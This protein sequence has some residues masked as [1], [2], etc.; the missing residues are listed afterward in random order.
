MPA[1]ID[2]TPSHAPTTA[3]TPTGAVTKNSLPTQSGDHVLTLTSPVKTGSVSPDAQGLV[4]APDTIVEAIKSV[5]FAGTGAGFKN[6]MVVVPGGAWIQTTRNADRTWNGTADL[7]AQPTGPYTVRVYGW[8]DDVAGIE[9][10]VALDFVMLLNNR[11]KPVALPPDPPQAKGMKLLHTDD[12]TKGPLNPIWGLGVRPDG[13]QW[14]SGA[15]FVLA[16]EPEFNQVFTFPM[17]SFLRIRAIHN[18]N[19]V[20]P[21]KW[22]RKFVS[23]LLCTVKP[24]GSG[25][26]TFRK[27]YVEAR[28]L[29]PI[30]KGMWPSLWA[31]NMGMDNAGAGTHVSGGVE[32]DMEFYCENPNPNKYYVS[33]GVINWAGTDGKNGAAG[34]MGTG[35]GGSVINGMWLD[36]TT[37]VRT[38]GILIDDT[39]VT[40]FIDDKQISQFALPRAATVDKFYWMLDNALSG[41]DWPLV[42][43]PAG[44]LD[45]FVDFIRLYSAD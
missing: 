22:N 12:F 37:A 42:V 10:Q 27:G 14:G 5:V 23:G 11:A 6:I 19:Y 16:N 9:Q 26:G 41:G 18:D 28:V 24:D 44:Y 15:H 7:S 2:P 29:F 38:I 40:W 3:P 20:D 1:I 4:A 39:K 34:T 30:G 35:T 8:W 45:M 31:Q 17:P 33:C 21:E 32:I 36:M 25:P 13:T 43:P